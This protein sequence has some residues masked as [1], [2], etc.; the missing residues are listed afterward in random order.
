MTKIFEGIVINNLNF[1]NEGLKVEIWNNVPLG[2]DK[3]LG[4]VITDESGKFKF[5]INDAKLESILDKEKLTLKIKL[6]KDDNLIFEDE[7]NVT[8][9]T[10]EIDLD[11]IIFNPG[12]GNIG[13]E[14]RVVDENGD[15][16]AGLVVL[17]EDVDYGKVEP[18][19]LK[20][21]EPKI[22]PI[23]PKDKLF[24]DNL[25]LIKNRYKNLLPSLD[26]YLGI[27]VT[28]DDGYYT[29]FYS[30]IKYQEIGDKEPD[31]QVTVKDKLGVFQLAKTDVHP[32][33]EDPV[34]LIDEIIIN[35]EKTEGWFVTI[36]K[37][38]P[39]RFTEDNNFEILI[40]NQIVLEKIVNILE[41][42]ESY[43]YLSQY[44]FYP[45][46]VTKFNSSSSQ[47]DKYEPVNIMVDNLLKAQDKGV[48]VRIIL[49]ENVVVPD[50]FDE[51]NDFFKNS[52]VNVRR[53]P[54]KGPY[55]MHAKVLVVDGK[56][57]FIIGSPFKQSFW[58]TN[59]HLTNDP[60]R[61]SND[62]GPVH[63]VSIYLQGGAV[64]HIEKFFIQ[65][66][67]YLSDKDFE[68]H[69]KINLKAEPPKSGSE[70]IQIVRSITPKS[71][72]KK[73]EL[74]VLEAYRRAITNAKDFIY[75]ENQYFTNRFIIEALK[76][77]I[78]HNPDLQLIMVINQVP[79]VPSYRSWQ[80][81]GFHKMGMDLKSLFD[82]P[83]IGIFTLWSGGYENG[84]SNLQHCYVHSK[85]A[86]IDDKWATIGTAN[87]DGSSLSCA[88]EFFVNTK[89][90][91]YL[92]MEINAVLFDLDDIKTCAVN[93]IRHSLWSEHLNMDLTNMSRPKNGWL[94][95]W[96][97][98]A[99]ENIR[100]LEEEK[101][102]LY[103]NILP[104]STK[105]DVKKEIRDLIEQFRRIKDRL[106]L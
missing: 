94:D 61:G 98:V 22:K 32:N 74:G 2:R 106:N 54:V 30:P 4:S 35:R 99:Y 20:L 81:H 101:I 13:L 41:K 64:T 95:L 59:K 65:L 34:K 93:K 69:D 86:I 70:P 25:K 104:Y 39:S 91:D 62:M 47:E 75:L 57:A 80:H 53:F 84:K 52:Q 56:G 33:V 85:I 68:G 78:A 18:G 48:D 87:L 71:V 42:A 50:S 28:D 9:N 96:K 46:L 26:D 102:T 76:S 66:W 14:G 77:A 97:K 92:N 17:A 24:K 51:I 1:P 45:N 16:I 19:V 31:I 63:D 58:D 100:A 21:F 79:D 15:P 72:H 67:N 73:G 12:E 3:L 10:Q 105:K 83:Q 40:D 44:E 60:R 55:A 27:S 23:F 103:G 36:D 88:E 7:R 11:T 89:P 29:I 90:K 5:Q 49:N 37:T 82:H 43:I 8:L 6:F 38:S